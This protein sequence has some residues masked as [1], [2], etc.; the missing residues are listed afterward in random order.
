M[1]ALQLLLGGSV[2]GR[3]A[4]RSMARL[5]RSAVRLGRAKAD[6]TVRAVEA[7]EAGRGVFPFLVPVETSSF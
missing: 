3:L 6:T 4:R 2:P 5:P 1:G 7:V